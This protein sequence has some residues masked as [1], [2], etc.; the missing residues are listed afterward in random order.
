MLNRSKL[1]GRRIVL[2][3]ANLRQIIKG[4]LLFQVKV[5]YILILS[6]KAYFL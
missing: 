5:Q 6:M 4:E 2:K 1:P 3:R